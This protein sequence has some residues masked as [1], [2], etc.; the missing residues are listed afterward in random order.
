MSE[1]WMVLSQV[2]ASVLAVGAVLGIGWFTVGKGIWHSI[3]GKEGWFAKLDKRFDR[4]EEEQTQAK[5]ERERDRLAQRQRDAAVNRRLD[6]LGR[7]V[8]KLTEGQQ[9][10]AVAIARLQGKE[11]ARLEMAQGL[12]GAG[13]IAEALTH[14]Q[15]GKE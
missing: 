14:Q 7:G 3:V 9:E 10:H 11:E 15:E 5:E 6:T 8:E 13:R 4:I 1:V 2:V 12:S